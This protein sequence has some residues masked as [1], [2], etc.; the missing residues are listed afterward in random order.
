[1]WNEIA[2]WQEKLLHRPDLA[3][4][5]VALYTQDARRFAT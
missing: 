2:A 1:M 4:K 3:V 5:T